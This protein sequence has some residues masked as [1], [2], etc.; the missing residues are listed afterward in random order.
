MNYNRDM[1]NYYVSG[2]RIM[3]IVNMFIN[4]VYSLHT[5]I[6][7]LND[8]YE[9]SFSDKQLHFLV[10]GLFGVL[11]IILIGPIFKW[12]AKKHLTIIITWIYVFTIILVLTFAIEIGQGFSGT[13]VM[14]FNDI[15]AGVEGFLLFSL[16][17]LLIIGIVYW[18]IHLVKSKK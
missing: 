15:V 17:L 11:L 10:V 16:I 3:Q 14:D 9:T 13:G 18:I 1:S 7:S 6:L 2:S 12:L 5:K 8:A 4:L